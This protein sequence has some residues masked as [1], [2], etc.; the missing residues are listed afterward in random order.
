MLYYGRKAALEEKAAKHFFAD[1]LSGVDYL[2]YNRIVH[3]DLKLDN[4]LLSDTWRVLIIDFGFSVIVPSQREGMQ[5]T[6]KLSED[7]HAINCSLEP[8]YNV[9]VA[10]TTEYIAPEIN[11]IAIEM[12][13]Y[14]ENHVPRKEQTKYR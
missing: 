6:S 3:R 1:M 7:V 8:L 4:C 11:A 13:R 14:E 2:H 10:G 5:A 12:R 9:T